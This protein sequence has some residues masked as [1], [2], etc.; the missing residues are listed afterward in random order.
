MCHLKATTEASVILP[1]KAHWMLQTLMIFGGALAAIFSVSLI[2]I[3]IITIV[4]WLYER[5]IIKRRQN[6][7][8]TQMTYTILQRRE[9]E[10]EQIPDPIFD[11][12]P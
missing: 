1:I 9:R 7:Q 11:H 12:I 3:T 5:W 4:S 10:Q 2:I 6:Q 8:S